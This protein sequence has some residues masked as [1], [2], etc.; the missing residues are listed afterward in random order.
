MSTSIPPDFN[1]QV[2][3]EFRANTDASAA[4]STG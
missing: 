2:I 4:C 3:E 1:E